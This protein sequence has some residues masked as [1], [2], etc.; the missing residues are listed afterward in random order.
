M[1]SL[2]ASCVAT[3][4]RG[5][6]PARGVLILGPSGAGKSALALRLLVLG[7]WLVADDRTELCAR[8]G[9][10]VAAA[11]PS[12]RGLIE[13]RGVGLLR[14]PALAEAELALA[15]DLGQQERRRMPPARSWSALG[16][17]LPLLHDPETSCFPDALMLYLRHGER[18]AG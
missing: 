12:V 9:A 5:G 1:T 10:L 18:L 6:R 13:A 3:P 7:A 15:V 17:A 4:P 8:D 16:I 14:L 2:H 11:P